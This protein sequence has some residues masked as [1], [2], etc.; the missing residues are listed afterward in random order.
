MHLD[1]LNSRDFHLGR[2]IRVA[3]REFLYFSHGTCS[4]GGDIALQ[5]LAN[6]WGTREQG[7]NFFQC[8]TGS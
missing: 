2:F 8:L 4:T 6:L 3:R 5:S 1:L 7:V